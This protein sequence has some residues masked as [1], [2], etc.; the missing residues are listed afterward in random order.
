ME[1]T[2]NMYSHVQNTASKNT[3]EILQKAEFVLRRNSASIPK[4]ECQRSID[5]AGFQFLLEKHI[6]T[7]GHFKEFLSSFHG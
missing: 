1:Q 6:S 5:I 4:L 7:S 3:L 2:F